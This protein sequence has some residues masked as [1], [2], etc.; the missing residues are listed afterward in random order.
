MTVFVAALSGCVRQSQGAPGGELTIIYLNRLPDAAADWAS[1]ASSL[2]E[3]KGNPLVVV[4]DTAFSDAADLASWQGEREIFLLEALGCDLFFPPAS[5]EL[6]GPRRLAGLSSRADFFIAALNI[7]DSSG[8]YLLPRY[9]IRQHSPY[10]VAFSAAMPTPY[11]VGG[12]RSLPLDSILPV[13]ASFLRMH[14]DY[15]FYFDADDSLPEGVNLIPRRGR[16]ARIDIRFVSGSEVKLR[17]REFEPQAAAKGESQL[18]MWRSHADSLDSEVLGTSDGLSADSLNSLALKALQRLIYERLGD[19]GAV[20]ILVDE[21]V[22][23]GLPAGEITLGMMR[24]VMRPEM[25]FLADASDLEGLISSP[26]SAYDAGAVKERAVVPFS[27]IL[28]NK[29]LK[30]VSLEPTGITYV[31]IAREIFTKESE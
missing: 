21:L 31:H 4:D 1:L 29:K 2:K 13:T 8:N 28:E 15:F 18:D 19:P 9:L 17:V 20:M 24:K 10:R 12:L 30:Q 11:D 14:S 5:W 23:A 6:L 27:L 26:E 25:F 7:A 3:F 22:S 16:N